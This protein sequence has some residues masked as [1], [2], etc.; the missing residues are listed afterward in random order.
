MQKMFYDQWNAPP[1]ARPGGGDGSGSE[2]WNRLYSADCVRFHLRTCIRLIRIPHTRFELWSWWKPYG[3]WVLGDG[4]R[5]IFVHEYVPI[6]SWTP[7]QAATLLPHW[8]W[9]HDHVE[10]RMFC[11]VTLKWNEARTTAVMNAALREI[12]LP[13]YPAPP[14]RT[15]SS[16]MEWS[17]RTVF[18]EWQKKD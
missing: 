12:G 18:I 7:G 2:W 3:C 9:V 6:I 5:V 16:T 4:R 14:P 13:N 17:K 1:P 10:T 8:I 15:Y 11:D